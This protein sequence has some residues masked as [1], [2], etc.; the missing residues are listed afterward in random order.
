MK[1]E[2]CSFPSPYFLFFIFLPLLPSPPLPVPLQISLRT[3]HIFPLSSFLS[4]EQ[5]A[6][7]KPNKT[8]TKIHHGALHPLHP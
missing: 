5:N 3:L 2:E 4:L 6:K 8:A 7:D 1:G